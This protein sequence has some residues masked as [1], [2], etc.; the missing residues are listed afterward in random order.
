MPQLAGGLIIYMLDTRTSEIRTAAIRQ[1]HQTVN[2][3]Q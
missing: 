2:P 3:F 1:N